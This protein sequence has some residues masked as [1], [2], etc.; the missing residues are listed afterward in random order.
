M[1]NEKVASRRVTIYIG[2]S[3]YTVSE[4]FSGESVLYIPMTYSDR[5]VLREC[6]MRGGSSEKFDDG[7][8]CELKM[9]PTYLTIVRKLVRVYAF[10]FIYKSISRILKNFMVYPKLF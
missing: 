2:L 5:F 4:A 1:S 6:L 3:S 9:R 8:I 10:E 7:I